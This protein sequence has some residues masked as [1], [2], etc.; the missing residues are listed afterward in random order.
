M[1][2]TGEQKRIVARELAR[3]GGNLAAAR[4]RLRDEYETF[5]TISE[6]TIRRAI[7]EP[8]FAELIGEEAALLAAAQRDAAVQ[9]ERE[10]ALR[11]LEGTIVARLAR[12]EHML[13]DLRTRIE[14]C[15]KDET[16]VAPALAAR[17]LG[18]LMKVTDRRRES[19]V[20]A[21]AETRE[22]T[23]LV[24]SFMEETVAMLGQAKAK[25]LI[26]R[27]KERYQQKVAVQQ[28]A[29]QRVQTEGEPANG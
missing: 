3:A 8:G 10:R 13:D 18:L 19:L 25:Q 27:V 7:K 26:A 9:A 4:A 28:Q 29:A 6:N 5:R 1:A 22:A 12:D 17:L 20:P 14:N 23:A 21:V 11:Q 2:Y 15:I 24:E 16:K